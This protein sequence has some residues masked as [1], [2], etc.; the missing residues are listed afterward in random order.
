MR[1]R[2]RSFAPKRA[3]ISAAEYHAI[4]EEVERLIAVLDL[5]AP[6][7]DM[8]PSLAWTDYEIVMNGDEIRPDRPP[9]LDDRELD[10]ADAEPSLGAPEVI[11]LGPYSR[12][13]VTLQFRRK[14]SPELWEGEPERTGELSQVIWANG[15]V[16]DREVECEDEGAKCDD[17]GALY[18][19]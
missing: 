15:G 6:D 3:L 14:Q 17:E 8:E 4:E 13:S 1:K 16:D 18:Q 7:P 9:V 5:L 19:T 2:K 12:S 10:E 11:F